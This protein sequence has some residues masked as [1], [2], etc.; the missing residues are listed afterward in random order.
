MIESGFLNHFSQLEDPRVIN[1]NT[2]HTFIEILVLAFVATLCGCDDWVEVTLFCKSKK[3][4]FKKFLELPNGIPSHDTFSRVFSMI[5]SQHFEEIFTVWMNELF[6]KTRGEIIALDGKTLRGSRHKGNNKGIHLVHAWACKN[7]LTLGAVRVDDKSN[8]ITA[9]PKLLKL[10]DV[11]D[12][13][14]TIDAMGCQK[15]IAEII[16]D[17]KANYVLNV[18]DNQRDLKSDIETIF[19]FEESKPDIKFSSS[20]EEHDAGHG[21]VETRQYMSL[22]MTHFPKIQADW[23]GLQSIT[24]VVRTRIL[25]EEKSEETLFFIS[26]HPYHSDK[27]PKAIRS[28]WHVENRLHWQLDISFQEDHCRVRIGHEAENVALLRRLSL[29]CLKKDNATKA[30]IKAK[31]KK[32]GWDDDYL[33]DILSKGFEK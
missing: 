24:K 2:R 12:C 5:D 22:P 13:T 7:Q 23:I 25:G 14:I 15:K 8:E 28:H 33:L 17:R 11:A 27:I 20:I 9:I 10:L 30:G 3:S 19:S 18:K 1:H 4:L 31:R 6:E 32:A 26:S 21:R 29:A 16:I